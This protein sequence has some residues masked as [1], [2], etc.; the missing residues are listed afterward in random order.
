MIWA[1]FGVPCVIFAIA[2][3][4]NKNVCDEQK[5]TF[6]ASAIALGVCCI[7]MVVVAYPIVNASEYDDEITACEE[8][9]AK[10]ETQLSDMVRDNG[11]KKYTGE[12]AVIYAASYPELQQN[13]YVKKEIDQYQENQ[14]KIKDAREILEMKKK[15]SKIFLLWT[16]N[17]KN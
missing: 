10:I 15:S 5:H 12:E 8:E 16:Q 7:V 6:K 13:E 1:I 17:T 9:N 11:H 3:F 14:K 2:M 4:T